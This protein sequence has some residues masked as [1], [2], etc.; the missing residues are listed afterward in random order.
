MTTVSLQMVGYAFVTV[1]YHPPIPTSFASCR[2]TNNWCPLSKPPWVDNWIGDRGRNFRE[3]GTGRMLS[4]DLPFRITGSSLKWYYVYRPRPP[5]PIC[6]LGVPHA[7]LVPAIL[8]RRPLTYPRR[9][10]GAEYRLPLKFLFTV[11]KAQK[12]YFDNFPIP[13]CFCSQCS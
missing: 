2:M 3:E 13:I 11:Q 8:L 10:G 6:S 12:I 5:R 7:I 9:P 4:R 1:L